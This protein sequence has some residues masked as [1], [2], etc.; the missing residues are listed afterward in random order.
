MTQV[1]KQKECAPSEVRNEKKGVFQVMRKGE[2]EEV[3]RPSSKAGL[4]GFVKRYLDFCPALRVSAF[5]KGNAVTGQSLDVLFEV[6]KKSW[7]RLWANPAL[8]E[9]NESFN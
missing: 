5:Q 6:F 7:I 9:G 3:Y 4:K 8:S 1:T 2:P